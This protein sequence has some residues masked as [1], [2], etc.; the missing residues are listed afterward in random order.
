MTKIL[1]TGDGL[2]VFHGRRF[3]RIPYFYKL[4]IA[5]NEHHNSFC[6][7]DSACLLCEKTET[8]WMAG[9]KPLSLFQVQYNDNLLPATG[10]AQVFYCLD[11]WGQTHLSPPNTDDIDFH[12]ASTRSPLLPFFIAF[13]PATS[14]LPFPNPPLRLHV[15]LPSNSQCLKQPELLKE[16]NCTQIMFDRKKKWGSDGEETE[17]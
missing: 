11:E 5:C 13:V 10:P 12:S 8:C 4:L 2:Q 17:R 15:C 16:V 6:L 3:F 14:L 7:G 9:G 1:H